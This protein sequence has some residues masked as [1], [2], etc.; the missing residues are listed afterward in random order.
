[1]LDVLNFM[2]VRQ[3]ILYRTMEFIQKVKLN[4]LPNYLS[5]EEGKA[6]DFE[7]GILSIQYDT[8]DLD[9]T[10]NSIIRAKILLKD[11]EPVYQRP[12][13]IA[14]EERQVFFKR[15][16][17]NRIRQTKNSIIRAKILLKDQEPV[18]QR[19]RRIAEEERQVFFKRQRENRIRFKDQEPVY[20]RPRRIAEEERQV[21]FKRQRENRIR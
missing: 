10:K 6:E 1:M 15:Q 12:R 17:E 2:S 13:R 14:E 5:E 7:F 18:Y 8:E 9:Q 3:E 21:F 19:P 11:Q 20:Q 16:R 4:L